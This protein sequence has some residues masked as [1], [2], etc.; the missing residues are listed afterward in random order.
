MGVF[1]FWK[2]NSLRSDTFFLTEKHP[3]TPHSLDHTEISEESLETVYESSYS[4]GFGL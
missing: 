1:F 3:H 2:K 4:L